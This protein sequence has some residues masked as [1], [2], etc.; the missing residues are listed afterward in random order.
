MT[1]HVEEKEIEID[2]NELKKAMSLMGESAEEKAAA[3][4]RAKVLAAVVVD[5]VDIK[6]VAAEMEIDPE[7]AKLTL[8]ESNGD[9][10]AAFRALLAH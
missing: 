2:E 1:D 4:E 6:L 8:Q 10:I 5:K 3:E 9:A 7:V